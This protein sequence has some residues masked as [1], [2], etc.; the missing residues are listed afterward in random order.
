VFRWTE[1]T[2]GNLRDY[3]TGQFVL[4]N[5]AGVRRFPYSTSKCALYSK[6][7]AKRQ[8]DYLV[9]SSTNPLRYSSLQTLHEVHSQYPFALSVVPSSVIPLHFIIKDIGEVWA[10]LLHNVHAALI[11]VHG[12]S[13]TA[14][15]N[16]T[17]TEGNI[18]FMHLFIDAL[19]LQPC[20]PNC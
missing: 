10:N 16:P 11:G 17:G 3:V 14:R 8:P 19:A 5:P 12:F 6:V 13:T 18:V 20:N 2:S 7:C 15:T 1:Q 4:D 9:Y